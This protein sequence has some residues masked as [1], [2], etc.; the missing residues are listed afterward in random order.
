MFPIRTNGRHSQPEKRLHSSCCFS[1]DQ[2]T[3]SLKEIRLHCRPAHPCTHR[4]A[5]ASWEQPW[6]SGPTRKLG[7]S[8]HGDA[9]L[10]QSAASSAATWVSGRHGENIGRG[11]TKKRR[12]QTPLPVLRASAQP[13]GITVDHA[14]P[15][16][17]VTARQH[18][19]SVAPLSG[20]GRLKH[21]G[22]TYPV[23]ACGRHGPEL[24]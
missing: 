17:G 7:A 14:S 19:R 13:A 9:F 15:Q 4:P 24:V 12:D 8:D 3:H 16:E 23:T 1:R 20:R 10:A 22:C 11:C 18:T 5:S 21:K 6:L 2:A